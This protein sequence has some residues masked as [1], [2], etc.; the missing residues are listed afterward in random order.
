MVKHQTH[1]GRTPLRNDD[2][3]PC[4]FNWGALLVEL[5]RRMCSRSFS[6]YLM[7]FPAGGTWDLG[8]KMQLPMRLLLDSISAA[9]ISPHCRAKVVLHWHT[10][11]IS[12]LV[13]IQG[14]TKLERGSSQAIECLPT[15]YS[16]S[17]ET[18]KKLSRAVGSLLIGICWAT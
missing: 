2:I 15:G 11:A 1:N 9:W 18:V 14:N 16:H 5:G 8:R 12:Y 17:Q 3:Q 6:F 10:V 7:T 4:L 13:Q